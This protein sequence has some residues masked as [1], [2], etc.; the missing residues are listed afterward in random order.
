MFYAARKL[1][2]FQHMAVKLVNEFYN[3]EQLLTPVVVE[4]FFADTLAPLKRD[5]DSF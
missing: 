5:G 3:W 1:T 4:R 2:N